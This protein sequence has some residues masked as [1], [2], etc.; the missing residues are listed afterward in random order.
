DDH[1]ARSTLARRHHPHRLS[2][3]RRSLPVDVRLVPCDA[4]LM[5]LWSVHPKYLDARGLVALWR[6]AL[7]AQAVL[8]GRTK[9]Y[10]HHPQLHRFWANTAPRS[11][12]NAYLACVLQEATARGYSFDRSKVGPVRKQA[13]I[14]VTAG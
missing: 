14:P 2:H 10:R 9:G 1:P 4:L 5:R 3:D 6:E 7:L 11:A 12:I 13:E 8:R